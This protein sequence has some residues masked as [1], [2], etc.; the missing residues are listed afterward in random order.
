MWP[1]RHTVPIMYG[2]RGSTVRCSRG[3]RERNGSQIAPRRMFISLL[4]ERRFSRLPKTTSGLTTALRPRRGATHPTTARTPRCTHAAPTTAR[5]PH[6]SPGSPCRWTHGRRPPRCRRAAS[7][8]CTTPSA[9]H[10][11]CERP[12]KSRRWLVSMS[13]RSSHPTHASAHPRRRCSGRV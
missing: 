1:S 5:A 7:A 3:A 6:P 4:A 9:P 2:A 11:R 10:A 13:H 12:P 8:G